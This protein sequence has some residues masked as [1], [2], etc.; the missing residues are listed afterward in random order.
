ME[1]KNL[2]ATKKTR[3]IRLSA[4]LE[5]KKLKEELT[6]LYNNQKVLRLIAADQQKIDR[7]ISISCERELKRVQIKILHKES[8]LGQMGSIFV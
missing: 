8:K 4:R 2:F 3:R 7:C 6:K 5:N 1:P